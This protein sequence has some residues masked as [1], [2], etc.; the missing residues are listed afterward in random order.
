M[1]QVIKGHVFLGTAGQLGSEM[2]ACLASGAA[3]AMVEAVRGV[4]GTQQGLPVRAQGAVTMH[5][6]VRLL[7]ADLFFPC[8]RKVCAR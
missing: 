4:A 6:A 8:L 1:M 5:D 3:E 2:C 7:P